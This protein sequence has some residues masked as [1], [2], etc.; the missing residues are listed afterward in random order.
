MF[1]RY[2]KG[3]SWQAFFQAFLSPPCAR[4]N[5]PAVTK[6]Y[7]PPQPTFQNLDFNFKLLTREILSI[8]PLPDQETSQSFCSSYQRQLLAR[9]S[10]LL[11]SLLSP[12]TYIATRREVSECRIFLGPNL[13]ATPEGSLITID[14]FW[15]D[16]PI[17]SSTKTRL[18][19]NPMQ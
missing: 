6:I 15:F 17:T 8:V 11:D 1:L 12:K 2:V 10:L 9:G 16:F 19:S 7:L 14:S 4:V 5:N 3:E 18:L 13:I